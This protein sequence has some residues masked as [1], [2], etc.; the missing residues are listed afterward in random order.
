MKLPSK[1][2]AAC[3]ILLQLVAEY[4]LFIY[5]PYPVILHLK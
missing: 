5:S 4:I 1:L 3:I 2:D